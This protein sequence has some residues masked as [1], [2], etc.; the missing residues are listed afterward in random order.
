MQKLHLT[1]VLVIATMALA[2]Q[3]AR[4]EHEKGHYSTN[5]LTASDFIG[6]KVT[7]TQ[8]EDLGKVQDLILNLDAGNVTVPYIIIAHG[9]VLGA[10][11]TKTAVPVSSF[12][13]SAD[14]KSLVLPMTK[15]QIQTAG[16]AAHGNWSSV[17]NAGWARSVDGFY[18]Q[19]YD[20]SRDGADYSRDRVDSSRDRLTRE[21]R[22]DSTDTRSFVREPA[23]K[24]AELLMQPADKALC[25]RICEATDTVRIHVENG[26]THLYGQ[27]PNEAAR[28]SIE[29]KVRA[30][31]GVQKVESHLK[32]KNP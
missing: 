14:G 13:C 4:A 22:Q 30:V 9:G 6:M 21:G 25:E 28:D 15:E 7:S 32:V 31:P 19:P 26:V 23:P 27:V 2:A 11:R 8:G 18:G 20:R 17:T 16:K 12:N 29:T 1:T 5:Q 3:S 24:G 10:G